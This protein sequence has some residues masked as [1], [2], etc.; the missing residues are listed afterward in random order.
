[1]EGHNSNEHNFGE[2][3][4]Q[5]PDDAQYLLFE[6]HDAWRL[7]GMLGYVSYNLKKGQWI[8]NTDGDRRQ[9]EKVNLSENQLKFRP[10]FIM[11]KHE[12]IDHE[13]IES[14]TNSANQQSIFF[15]GPYTDIE[16]LY[17]PENQ[18]PHDIKDLDKLLVVLKAPQG[19][20]ES[21]SVVVYDETRERNCLRTHL[22]FLRNM[23]YFE[24]G[25]V[26]SANVSVDKGGKMFAYVMYVSMQHQPHIEKLIREQDERP[27]HETQTSFK[28]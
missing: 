25:H 1:M 27:L 11:D 2:L 9:I 16:T 23:K 13:L 17:I 12:T 5:G 7:A 3:R 28:F 6:T 15:C 26:C 4:R 24:M 20:K 19:Y 18:T 21:Y 10:A 8:R 22:A 14:N